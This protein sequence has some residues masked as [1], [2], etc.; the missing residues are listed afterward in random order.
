M[1]TLKL[2]YDNTNSNVTDLANELNKLT[3]EIDQIKSQMDEIGSGMTDS[4]P[5]IEIKQ[6]MQKLK[7][8][9][10]GFFFPKLT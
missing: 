10:I 6:G 5:L 4:K 3:E 2:K 8:I 7:V 9:I 1:A